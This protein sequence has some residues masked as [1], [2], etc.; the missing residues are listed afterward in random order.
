MN[1]NVVVPASATKLHDMGVHPIAAKEVPVVSK[2]NVW[3]ALPAE[4][5]SVLTMGKRT[6]LPA[7]SNSTR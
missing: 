5:S 7:I 1:V 4:T 2:V 3:D 6:G